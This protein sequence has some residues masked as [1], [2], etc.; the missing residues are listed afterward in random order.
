[1]GATEWHFPNNR[2]TQPLM[3]LPRVHLGV[4]LMPAEAEQRRVRKRITQ[5][6]S[7][8]YQSGRCRMLNGY[9]HMPSTCHD[10]F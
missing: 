8:V 6:T 7:P 1:M 10:D 2:W 9:F 3:T 5:L 4:C